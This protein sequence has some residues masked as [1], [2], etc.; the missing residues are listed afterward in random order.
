MAKV[1]NPVPSYPVR[2]FKILRDGEWHSRQELATK[3]GLDSLDKVAANMVRLRDIYLRETNVMAICVLR[4]R[5][6]GFILVIKY[7]KEDDDKF[8]Q[9][10]KLAL[11]ALEQQYIDSGNK[12]ES[13]PV[14]QV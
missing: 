9:D 2:L 10:R 11:Q 4:N 12:E 1:K 6:L 5:A 13:E 7:T 3:C 14:T 8:K